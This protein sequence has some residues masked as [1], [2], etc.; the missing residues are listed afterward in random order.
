ML[1]ERS[2]VIYTSFILNCSL[3]L[4]CNI[5]KLFHVGMIIR[6]RVHRR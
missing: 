6:T 2:G 4:T 3:N 5:I 1:P